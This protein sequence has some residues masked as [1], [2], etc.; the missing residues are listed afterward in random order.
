MIQIWKIRVVAGLEIVFG[1]ADAGAGAHHLH[2]AGFGA[3]F[4]AQAVLVRDRA[5]AD[6]GD[7]LHVAM[8]M[9]RKAGLR[10]DRR[11][12]SRRASAP[13]PMRLASS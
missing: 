2:V 10:R 12:H 5:L 13:Q 7:D 11:R 8:R 4:V 6:I 9:R 3:A 1:V